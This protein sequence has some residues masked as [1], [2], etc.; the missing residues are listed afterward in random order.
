MVRSEDQTLDPVVEFSLPPSWQF[1]LIVHYKD[2]IIAARLSGGQ[3]YEEN[4]SAVNR[5][6]ADTVIRQHI[7]VS[8]SMYYGYETDLNYNGWQEILTNENLVEGMRVSELKQLNL[9]SWLAI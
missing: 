4:L 9:G 2:I 7:E 3:T 5:T 8:Q 1:L 6:E